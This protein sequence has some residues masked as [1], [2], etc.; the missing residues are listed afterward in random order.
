MI[1]RKSSRSME[2]PKSFWS[3]HRVAVRDWLLR[4]AVVVIS[5]SVGLGI[6]IANNPLETFKNF[7]IAGSIIGAIDLFFEKWIKS[8]I[9]ENALEFQMLVILVILLAIAYQLSGI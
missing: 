9:E 5:F 2:Q 1:K 8:I 3:E 6:I 7:I 4:V